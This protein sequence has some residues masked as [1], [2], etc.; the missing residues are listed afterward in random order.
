VVAAWWKRGRDRRYRT[1]HYLGGN[2]AQETTPLFSDPRIVVEY[3]PP[4]GLRPAQMGL[5]LDERADTLDVTATIID[6]AVR[7]YVH[8]TEIPKQG[9][10][11]NA[12]WRLNRLTPPETDLLPYERRLIN[13]MF[14]AGK[15]EVLLSDLKDK[16]ATNLQRV[17]DD[18]YADAR[19]RDWFSGNPSTVKALWAG[20]GVALAV[21]GVAAAAASGFLLGRALIGAP[22]ALAGLVMIALAPAM[23]RRTA[24]GSEALRR[25]LGF[26]EYIVMAETHRQEF[27]EQQ[28]IF[29]RY[30]PFAI[31]FECVDRWAKAFEGIEGLE[32]NAQSS[33]ASWYTG[34]TLLSLS[35]I[36]SSLGSISSSFSSTISST[37]SSSGGSGFSGGSAGG[38]GGGGGGGRW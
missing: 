37:P 15:T 27:N 20:I 23:S 35:S 12:D 3:L 31:V 19:K 13:A 4:E 33:M 25:V 34:A 8:I 1:I 2:D 6:L 11:G 10:F 14:S 22:L 24:T 30:L 17:K 7:G 9:W 29:A 26:R 36:S 5:L 38:G 28:N 18:L 32:A 21:S 16:F